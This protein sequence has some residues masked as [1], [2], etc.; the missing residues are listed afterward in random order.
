MYGPSSKVSAI[1]LGSVHLVMIVLGAGSA[2]FSTVG[3]A[4]MVGI[5]ALRRV[6]EVRM[7][8]EDLEFLALC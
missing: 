6:R 5:R 1:V 4:R 7:L 2:R 8:M 3:A